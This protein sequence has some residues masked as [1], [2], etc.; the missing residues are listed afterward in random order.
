MLVT[1]VFVGFLYTKG[2]CVDNKGWAT[3]GSLA[4]VCGEMEIY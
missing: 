1:L 3:I 4:V 2:V